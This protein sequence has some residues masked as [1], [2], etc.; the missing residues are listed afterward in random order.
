MDEAIESLFWVSLVAFVA[1]IFVVRGGVVYVATRASRSAG[2]PAFDQRESAAMALFASIGLPIIV[3]VTSVAVDAGDMTV[4]NASVLVAGGAFTVL[5]CPFHA[6]RL[7][8]RR[9]PDR[10]RPGGPQSP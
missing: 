8:I 1:M 5:V 2:Q 7:L 10:V 3:A 9:H 4:T 6:Q